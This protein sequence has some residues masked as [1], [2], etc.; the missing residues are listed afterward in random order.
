[1]LKYFFSH[2]TIYQQNL[3]QRITNN[4]HRIVSIDG[5]LCTP[6]GINDVVTTTMSFYGMEANGLYRNIRAEQSLLYPPTITRQP[7]PTIEQCAL[8]CRTIS[9]P[10]VPNY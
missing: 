9:T 3:R 10:S 7:H 8:Y 2:G 4:H 6:T 5:A 1:M